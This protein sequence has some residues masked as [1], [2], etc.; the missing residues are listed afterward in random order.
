M[1]FL[2]KT[3]DETVPSRVPRFYHVMGDIT[4]YGSGVDLH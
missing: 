3:M 1:I 4:I 2:A